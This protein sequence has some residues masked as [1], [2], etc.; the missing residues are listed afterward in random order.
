MES[1][2]PCSYKPT[3]FSVSAYGNVANSIVFTEK[4]L[5]HALSVYIDS[6]IH[7]Q[8]NWKVSYHEVPRQSQHYILTYAV[9]GSFA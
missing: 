5:E 7:M 9:E 8:L 2:I 4:Y 1:E 3:N 6:Y